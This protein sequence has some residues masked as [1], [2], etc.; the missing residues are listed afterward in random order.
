MAP[1]GCL[2]GFPAVAAYQRTRYWLVARPNY[3]SLAENSL[4]LGDRVK[5]ND[6]SPRSHAFQNMGRLCGSEEAVSKILVLL[7]CF[8][9]Q[10]R[11]MLHKMTIE[12]VAVGKSIRVGHGSKK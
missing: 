2:E 1:P 6:V 8:G 12:L 11:A 5:P 7:D 3:P 9:A 4:R 10:I